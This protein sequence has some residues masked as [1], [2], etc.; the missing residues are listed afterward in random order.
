MAHCS[1]VKG[2]YVYVSLNGIR[3]IELSTT[4]STGSTGM[5]GYQASSVF[6]RK[7]MTAQIVS[8]SGD[9]GVE[10]YALL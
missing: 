8:S 4:G 6:V 9:V 2:Q 1:Y 10:F 3:M 7:G 5:Q